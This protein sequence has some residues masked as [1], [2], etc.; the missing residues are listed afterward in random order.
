MTH[1][2][3][4]LHEI[5]FSQ[6]NGEF[7]YEEQTY[8]LKKYSNYYFFRNKKYANHEFIYSLNHYFYSF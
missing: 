7:I 4:N 2:P 3:I 6:H 8:Q 5:D 1:Q